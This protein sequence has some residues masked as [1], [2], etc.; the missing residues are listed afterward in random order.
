MFISQCIFHVI[1]ILNKLFFDFHTFLAIKDNE[2]RIDKKLSGFEKLMQYLEEKE[3]RLTQELIWL[4]SVRI[5][6]A[7][8]VETAEEV[9]LFEEVVIAA[10]GKV[11]EVESKYLEC[12]RGRM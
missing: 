6:I 5:L 2:V 1:K 4:E 3:N 11:V 7:G 10:V 12:L 9:E 8:T